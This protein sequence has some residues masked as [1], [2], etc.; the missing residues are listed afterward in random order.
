MFAFKKTWFP[1][2]TSQRY[3]ESR[4]NPP[5]EGGITGK[6]VLEKILFQLLNGFVPPET[7]SHLL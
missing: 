7:S 4:K 5:Q 6:G 2:P 1:M 3:E